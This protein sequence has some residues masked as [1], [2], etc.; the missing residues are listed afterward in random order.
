MITGTVAHKMLLPRDIF[1]NSGAM[2]SSA[3]F[4][5]EFTPLDQILSTLTVFRLLAED[6]WL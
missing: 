3:A 2:F 6:T 4:G 1:R 5:V